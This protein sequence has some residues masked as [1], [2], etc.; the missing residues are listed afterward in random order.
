LHCAI[1]LL[2]LSSGILQI[3]LALGADSCSFLQHFVSG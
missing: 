2:R 1:A 3:S